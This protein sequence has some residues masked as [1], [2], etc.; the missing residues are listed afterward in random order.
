[1]WYDSKCRNLSTFTKCEENHPSIKEKRMTIQRVQLKSF[2]S[3][4]GLPE[5]KVDSRFK[6]GKKPYNKDGYNNTGSQLME[7]QISKKAPATLS[8]DK[9]NQYINNEEL[10]P[11]SHHN[12]TVIKLHSKSN[13]TY[14]K[15]LYNSN[16]KTAE[17]SFGGLLNSSNKVAKSITDTRAWKFSQN[18]FTKWFVNKAATNQAVFEALNAL[19]ITCLLRPAAILAQ[20]NDTNREKNKKAASHSIAS[21]IIGYGFAVALFTPIAQGL[22]KIKKEPEKYAKKAVDFFKTNGTKKVSMEA[23]KKFAAYTMI[24]TYGPQLFTAAIRSGIT[25][26]M[27]PII[28][29]LFLNKLFKST[30][31]SKK[32]VPPT[33]DPMYNYY[34]L[35]FSS[36]QPKK[37]FQSFTG[38]MK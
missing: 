33:I 8:K 25:I 3:P 21:G 11:K 17:I 4:E 37:A 13:Y 1:M 12:S 24:C 22:S 9:G 32:Y 19:V 14:N 10:Y 2:T 29:K 20:S 7:A 5:S 35:N 31:D 6:E 16:Q 38:V 28:D 26:G 30:K 27:I 18:K 34:Y 36:N 15:N 23:S